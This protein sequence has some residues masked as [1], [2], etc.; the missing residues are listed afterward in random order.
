MILRSYVTPPKKDSDAQASDGQ[1]NERQLDIDRRGTEAVLTFERSEGR[2]PEK[3]DHFNPG[4]DI[5]SRASDGEMRFI[6]VKSMSG[7]WRG[8]SVGMSPEQVRFAQEKG[9][10]AWLYVVENLDGEVP[11]VHPIRDPARRITEFRFD[12]GWT[13]AAEVAKLPGKRRS[14]LDVR[15]RQVGNSSA[16]GEDVESVTET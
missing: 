1:S 10:R 3:M 16:G 11:K 6:E 7:P 12:E 8:F 14:I 2:T 15:P 13:Q 4:Y 9:D 5:E